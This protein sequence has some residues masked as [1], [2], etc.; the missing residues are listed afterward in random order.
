LNVGE[1]GTGGKRPTASGVRFTYN[2][3][4]FTVTGVLKNDLDHPVNGVVTAVLFDRNN[5]IIGSNVGGTDADTL[6]PGR[7]SLFTVDFIWVGVDPSR[8]AYVRV[9]PSAADG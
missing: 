9:T 1:T 5:N 7:K 3:Q 4:Y 8:V 6:P 2:G